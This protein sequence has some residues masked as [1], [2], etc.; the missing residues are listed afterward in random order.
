MTP[1]RIQ[2][3]SFLTPS[4]WQDQSLTM[5]KIPKTHEV[6]EASFVITRDKRG[7]NQ[8]FK[9]YLRIQLQQSQDQLPD[10]QLKKDESFNFQETQGG[11][12]EYTWHDGAAALYVRQIFYDLGA[13]VL[14][15]TLTCGPADINQHDVNWRRVMSSLKLVPVAQESAPD[16]PL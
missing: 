1:Y 12:F 4:E 2:E 11:W 15:C 6:G 7:N 3:A 14:I 9:D 8:L 10:F 5:F 13:K 16:F